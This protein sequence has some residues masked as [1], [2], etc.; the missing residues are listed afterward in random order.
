MGSTSCI[1][2]F[3][4]PPGQVYHFSSLNFI[5][6]DFGKISILDSDSNQ[7]GGDNLSAPFGLPN[8]A[9]I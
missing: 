7:S 5:T 9:E 8:A 3:T 6:N 2:D 1:N 4:F